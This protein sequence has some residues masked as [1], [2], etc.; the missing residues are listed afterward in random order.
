[1]CPFWDYFSQFMSDRNLNLF[2]MWQLKFRSKVSWPLLMEFF[3]ME[4]EACLW[5]LKK[6]FW[7]CE[8]L[9]KVKSASGPVVTMTVGKKF[10]I[11]QFIGPFNRTEQRKFWLTVLLVG[12]FQRTMKMVICLD[13]P[14]GQRKMSLL[15][16]LS[17]RSSGQRKSFEVDSCEILSLR[18]TLSPLKP[19]FPYQMS[20][21]SLD[22]NCVLRVIGITNSVIGISRRRVDVIKMPI[23]SFLKGFT[24]N[25]RL[26]TQTR[27]I[28]WPY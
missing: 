27:K 15:G 5:W 24:A 7:M 10:I 2:F 4:G 21:T 25:L 20:T 11:V 23:Y 9:K 22:R 13:K 18:Q 12:F 8:R 17:D 1:M 6:S 28:I 16:T 3:I 19:K 14:D 26:V